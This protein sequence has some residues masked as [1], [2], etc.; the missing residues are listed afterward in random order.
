[1]TEDVSLIGML[2]NMLLETIN[3]PGIK[4][5]KELKMKNNEIAKVIMVYGNF[6]FSR[7]KNAALVHDQGEC[8]LYYSREL[9]H[10]FYRGEIEMSCFDFVN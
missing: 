2:K 9:D 3:S 7:L 8:L 6:V 4:E 10:I 5:V 1:M